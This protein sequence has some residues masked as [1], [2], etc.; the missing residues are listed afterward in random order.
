LVPLPALA[1]QLVL[2][3]SLQASVPHL[4]QVLLPQSVLRSYRLKVLPRELALRLGLVSLRRLQ[5][6][7][8]PALVWLQV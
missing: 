6:V 1:L 8:P 7:Q 5:S 4:E 3:R 2:L